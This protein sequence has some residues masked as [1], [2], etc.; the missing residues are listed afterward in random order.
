MG[1]AYIA[2]AARSAGHTVDI[3]DAY[4][5]RWSWSQLRQYFTNKRYDVIGLTAMT[6][7]RDVVAKA[8][9]ICRPSARFLV[10]GGPHPTAVRAAVFE[11]MPELD[12]AIV[13]EESRA[14]CSCCHGGAS[15]IEEPLSYHQ[16]CLLGLQISRGHS[17][18]AGFHTAAST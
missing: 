12:A 18:S 9:K 2:A 16:V 6:P 17:S 3:F 8:V 7:M 4:A 11:E 1:L 5:L 13:G 10:I 14:L 15:R